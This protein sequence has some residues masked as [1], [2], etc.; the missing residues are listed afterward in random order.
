MEDEN[1]EYATPEMIEAAVRNVHIKYYEL[2]KR[3]GDLLAVYL[4]GNRLDIFDYSPAVVDFD[5]K[6]PVWICWWQGFENAP[7]VVRI[8]HSNLYEVMDLSE[9]QIVE[10]TFDNLRDYMDFPDWIWEK[11]NSGIITKTQLSDLLRM[12]LLYYYGGL[13]MDATYYL[14]RTMDAKSL[15]RK[16]LYTI[17]QDGFEGIHIGQGKWT[18][19][20]LYTTKGHL[21]PQFILNAFYYYYAAYNESLDYFL[22]DYLARII[23]NHTDFIRDEVDSL[24][25]EQ[26]DLYL[27]QDMLNEPYPNERFEEAKEN[28]YLYKL[29]Y[30]EKELVTET[31]DGR[32]TV[33]GHLLEMS[34]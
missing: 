21:F 24:L 20:F 15:R 9:F 14:T 26:K 18:M 5:G 30:Y 7:E 11:Y 12:G 13:W 27:L 33:F 16:D 10:I 28:T 22:V 31:A 8:C 1:I 25:P 3:V 17:H 2:E 4:Q 23:Y 32:Q 34:K 6:I 19:N 29:N